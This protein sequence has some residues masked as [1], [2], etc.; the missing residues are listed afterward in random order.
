MSKSNMISSTYRSKERVESWIEL[1][2]TV[3]DDTKK[4]ER[5]KAH[6]CKACFYGSHI[7]GQA[8][9]SQPCMACHK[10][11]MYSSTYTDALCLECSIDMQLC[12][13][14]G[15]DIDLRIKRRKWPGDDKTTEENLIND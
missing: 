2:K 10:D 15:G 8:I 3:Q 5:I 7:G 6:F 4:H 9:R 14:C 13:H 1:A 12:K 11:Q